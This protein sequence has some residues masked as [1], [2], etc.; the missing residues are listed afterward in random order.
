MRRASSRPRRTARLVTTG[1]INADG[2]PIPMMAQQAQIRWAGGRDPAAAT[3][4]RQTP[5]PQTFIGSDPAIIPST[6]LEFTRPTTRTGPV[7]AL[8]SSRQPTAEVM[9]E[10]SRVIERVTAHHMAQHMAQQTEPSESMG[11]GQGRS[12]LA[13]SQ[14]AFGSRLDQTNVASAPLQLPLTVSRWDSVP[15][16]QAYPQATQG[17]NVG[18]TG[19][20]GYNDMVRTGR[21]HPTM[22][23][24]TPTLPPIIVNPSTGGAYPA[25]SYVQWAA[26]WGRTVHIDGDSPTSGSHGPVEGTD[27]TTA[28]SNQNGEALGH[29]AGNGG[30]GARG[31][32][33][34]SVNHN[35]NNSYGTTVYSLTSPNV[36]ESNGLAQVTTRAAASVLA[37]GSGNGENDANSYNAPAPQSTAW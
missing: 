20:S 7:T 29:G 5:R 9:E 16:G 22:L 6:P 31:H 35:N 30:G 25:E 15:S 13:P 3:S 2:S 14:T 19:A 33:S 26:Q 10:M 27:A 36:H 12:Q 23:I 34:H 37:T 1:Q 11:S 17:S 4:A 24:G 32:H 8:N 18:G 21:V 28:S